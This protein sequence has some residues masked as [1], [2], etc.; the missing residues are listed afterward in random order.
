MFM[1]RLLIPPIYDWLLFVVSIETFSPSISVWV[2]PE[3]SFG[4][5]YLF[6]FYRIWPLNFFPILDG[7]STV[8]LTNLIDL[9]IGTGEKFDYFYYGR[10]NFSKLTDNCCFWILSWFIF[11]MLIF[12]VLKY[13][14]TVPFKRSWLF[15][16]YFNSG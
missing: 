15:S 13:F 5:L 3:I 9:L 6:H 16:A 11:S 7:I 8:F 12:L 2:I 4:D 14:I 1:I 10:D